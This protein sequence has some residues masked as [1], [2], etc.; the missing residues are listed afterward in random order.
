MPLNAEAVKKLA[1]IIYDAQQAPHDIVKLTDEYPDMTPEDGYLVLA[2]L[3]KRWLA[4][5]RRIVGYKAGLTSKAKMDQ[6]GVQHPAC[7][8]LFADFAVPDGGEAKMS[9]LIHPKVEP[10]I[11]VVTSKELKGHVTVQDVRNAID[12][13]VPAIEVI[14]S[15][16]RDFKF[17][18]QSVLADNSSAVKYVTGNAGRRYTPDMELPLMGIVFERNGELVATAAGAAIM[19][20][21]S[22]AVVSIVKWLDGHGKTLPAGS[23]VLTGGATAAFMVQAGDVWTCKVQGCGSTSIRFV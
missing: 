17:D 21:P 4:D 22:E 11:A 5:G 15:R 16:Y 3:E 7:A 19:E 9:E 23:L 13:V 8:I 6:M 10:E 12:F 18:I 14:D 20:D 2:E 1:D